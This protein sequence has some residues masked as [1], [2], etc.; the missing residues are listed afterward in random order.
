MWRFS[1]KLKFSKIV[2]VRKYNY[3]ELKMFVAGFFFPKIFY[4]ISTRIH[5]GEN[6]IE[7]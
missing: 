3:V 7:R 2:S 1:E 5:T 4:L 6:K